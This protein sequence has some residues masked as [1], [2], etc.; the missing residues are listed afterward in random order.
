[1]F[2]GVIA[3][4]H[5]A[6]LPEPEY[7]KTEPISLRN[8]LAALFFVGIAIA[9]VG[10]SLFMFNIKPA[11]AARSIIR[12]LILTNRPD[13]AG[14]TDLIVEE[15]RRGIKLNTF[16][17]TEIREQ[18]NSI[19]NL[20]L[21]DPGI[22]QQDKKKYLDFVIE[23]LEKQMEKEPHDV[24][25]LAF[26]SSAYSVAGKHDKALATVDKALAISSK[27]QHFYF[28]AAE[29]YLASNRFDKAVEV[30][31]TAYALDPQYPEAAHN[32]GVVLIVSGRVKEAE[33]FVEKQFGTRI[34]ADAKYAAAYTAIGDLGKAVQVWEKL[35][36]ASPS[37]AQ[38]RA[39]LGSAYLQ[40]G[41]KEKAIA[42]FKKAID[43]EPGFKARGEQIIREIQKTMAR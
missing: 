40:V 28:I 32:L 2:F 11:L 13:P 8:S 14:K 39:E 34:F 4:V 37:N 5:Q 42:Q 12:A 35:V 15:L 41:Q 20:V 29:S 10:Y 27:R 24:R 19:G 26:L 33:D 23:E 38:Y 21:G 17:T 30:L 1:M 22:A 3:W 25:A 18:A 16:G 43:L 9:V 6:S 36:S 7:V 31:R